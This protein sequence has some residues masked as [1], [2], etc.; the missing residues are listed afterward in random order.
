M[1][2]LAIDML[3]EW[4]RARLP[5]LCLQ[6]RHISFSVRVFLQNHCTVAGFEFIGSGRSQ[7]MVEMAYILFTGRITHPD[8]GQCHRE[9][10]LY[11]TRV[12]QTT[13]VIKSKTS[14]CVWWVCQ[15]VRKH[16]G[17]TGHYGSLRPLR[18]TDLATILFRSLTANQCDSQQ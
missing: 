13:R 10:T 6:Q 4:L 18:G 1:H 7:E 8:N 15:P 17:Y 16:Y 11:P 9:G 3:V 12:Y 2:V 5:R 14:S